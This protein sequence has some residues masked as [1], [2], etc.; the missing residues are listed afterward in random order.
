MRTPASCRRPPARRGGCLTHRGVQNS[1]IFDTA[2]GR[3]LTYE[4]RSVGA[5][6]YLDVPHGLV[7][8]RDLFIEQT[9]RQGLD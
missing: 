1:L 2:T 7:R 5:H 3:L 8:D 6:E 9:R 4:Q